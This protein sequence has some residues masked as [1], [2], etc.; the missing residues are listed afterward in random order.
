MCRGEFLIKKR[1]GCNVSHILLIKDTGSGESTSPI[2]ADYVRSIF[3]Y[4][5]SKFNGNVNNKNITSDPEAS[6]YNKAAVE[7]KKKMK[8]RSRPGIVK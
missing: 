6:R 7:I 1:S 8:C 3:I 5:I 2:K 4:I